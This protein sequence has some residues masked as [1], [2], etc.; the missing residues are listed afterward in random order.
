MRF[1]VSSLRGPPDLALY[2]GRTR[3]GLKLK[4]LG[5][6]AGGIDYVSVSSAVRRFTLRLQH[7]KNLPQTRGNCLGQI[8]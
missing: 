8:A 5:I 2:P 4:Q 3:C 7:D 6:L 1:S